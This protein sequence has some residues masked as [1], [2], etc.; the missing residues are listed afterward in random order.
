[1]MGL[2]NIYDKKVVGLDSVLD[3]DRGKGGDPLIIAPAFSRQI[4]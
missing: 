1:M 3:P 4:S 2:P